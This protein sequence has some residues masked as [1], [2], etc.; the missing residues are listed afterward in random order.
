P[1]LASGAAE[2]VTVQSEESGEVFRTLSGAAFKGQRAVNAQLGRGSFAGAA[3]FL[4]AATAPLSA[5]SLEKLLHCPYRFL[6]AKLGLGQEA[7]KEEDDPLEEG[8]WLHRILEALFIGAN[9]ATEMI[10]RF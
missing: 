6:L 5:A 1:L 2:L 9:T 7:F 8:E 3:A 10:E 4:E